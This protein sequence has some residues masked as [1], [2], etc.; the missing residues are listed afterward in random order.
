MCGHHTEHYA[1]GYERYT[2]DLCS[3][4]PT[5]NAGHCPINEGL[6]VKWTHSD[7]KMK[8]SKCTETLSDIAVNVVCVTN[9][10]TGNVAKKVTGVYNK[11]NKLRK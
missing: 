4:N 6:D 8:C 11:S 10:V 5:K 3:E 7:S 1:C 2:H 9:K